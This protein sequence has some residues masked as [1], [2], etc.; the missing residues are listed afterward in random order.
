MSISNLMKQFTK[1][2][3]ENNFEKYLNYEWIFSYEHLIDLNK[4]AYT[5]ISKNGDFL[6]ISPNNETIF[7]KYTDNLNLNF[8]KVFK[9]TSYLDDLTY[10]YYN[11]DNINEYDLINIQ[12]IIK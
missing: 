1:K 3:I 6:H 11:E 12:K 10:I 4:N 7:L 9:F 8:D 2:E 5:F